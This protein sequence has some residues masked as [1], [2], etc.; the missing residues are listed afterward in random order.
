LFVLSSFFFFL[1]IFRLDSHLS[2]A[3]H[4]FYNSRDENR[5]SYRCLQMGSIRNINHSTVSTAYREQ[6]IEKVRNIRFYNQFLENTV[7][8][9]QFVSN[10]TKIRDQEGMQWNTNGIIRRD[11]VGFPF[12]IRRIPKERDFGDSRQRIK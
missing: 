6:N 10:R 7:M 8:M 11:C 3:F 1:V 9:R 4:T 2:S 12:F 5:R